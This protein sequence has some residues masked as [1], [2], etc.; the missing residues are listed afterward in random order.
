MPLSQT[1]ERLL[2]S[3]LPGLIIPGTMAIAAAGSVGR[4]NLRSEINLEITRFLNAV[5]EAG[6]DR[7]RVAYRGKRMIAVQRGSS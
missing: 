4:G 1:D 5:P 3:I 2:S 7:Y 6:P